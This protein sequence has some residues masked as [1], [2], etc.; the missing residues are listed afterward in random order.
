[1]LHFEM[2]VVAA[3]LVERT[4]EGVVVP[5]GEIGVINGRK[6]RFLP[7]SARRARA[8]TPLLV[9]HNRGEPVGV[10]AELVDSDRGALGRF[11]VDQTPS[12]DTALVQAASGSRGSLSV[13][14]ELVSFQ[15][16]GDV[17]DVVEAAIHE[18]SLLALGAF[19]GATVT[20]VAAELAEPPDR[21]DEPDPDQ[22][23]L[24]LG[25]PGSID[26]TAVEREL[27]EEGDEEDKPEED[28][29]GAAGDDD[30]PEEGSTMTEA[31]AAAPV[32]IA[33]A[34]RPT[35]ELQAGE[36]VAY[37]IRAQHGEPEARRFLE[38]ALA[39]TISTDVSGLLPPTYERAVIGGK[40]V[41]RPLY[42][43]FRSRPLP[44]VGLMVSKPKWTT[45]PDGVW[46]AT[47]DADA[48]S[49]KAV[50]GS[51]TADIA[52]WDWAGAISWV[53]VQRSDPSIIDEI[54]AEAVQ[55]FYLDVEGKVYAE[56]SAASPG[57]ATTLGA[58]I[59]EFYVA[60]G[61]E[62]S[63]EV[64]VMAPDVWGAFADVGALSTPLA[65]GGVSSGDLTTT[66][67]GIPAVTSGTL[68]A[69]E[70]ILATRRAVDAR[71]TE[72]VRLTANAIGAL[73]VELAVV[74][75]GLFDTDYPTELLKFAAITP[76]MATVAAGRSS[77]SS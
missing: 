61:N 71:V 51:Q 49:T 2:D 26:R 53:V 68:A 14:A 15:E 35:R 55:D 34:D 75:E 73:N 76:A 1:M 25:E 62:R 60:T 24:E 31:Q 30:D 3:D 40:E 4:I 45:R 11:R 46:A 32:I 29:A 57:L 48:T 39:E 54:Y 27:G 33:G 56:L 16:D 64:I 19:D 77:R 38:A 41:N 44:G 12:G 17:I 74:G 10:L 22:T 63:P 6:Y 36:L 5:Y 67:A 21:D 8:R 66:F 37:I 72:P 52:R 28:D 42:T 70:T 59:A 18:I 65:Q 69:G 23:E 20:R 43:A 9:D 7:G 13:G 50:I 47:V 58:A